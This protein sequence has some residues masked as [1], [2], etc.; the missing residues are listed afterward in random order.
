MRIEFLLHLLSG[1]RNNDDGEPKQ[2]YVRLHRTWRNTCFEIVIGLLLLAL[3][4]GITLKI[5][6]SGG[7]GV[8][9]HFNIAGAPDSYGS[10][11]WLLLLGGIVTG[12]AVYYMFAAYRPLEMIHVDRRVGNMRQVWLLVYWAYVFTIEIILFGMLIV[13][14]GSGTLAAVLFKVVL[15]V[16]VATSLGVLVL[17]RAFA[18]PR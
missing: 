17:L 3:W 10:P 2:P 13:Y 12:L 6:T 7:R 9:I 18:R 8:P 4:V 15:F 14:G 16:I 5:A 1:R 11:Y